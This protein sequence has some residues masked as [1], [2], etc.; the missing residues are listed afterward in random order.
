MSDDTEL[1]GIT[2]VTTESGAPKPG[3]VRG[4]LASTVGRVVVIVLA[5]VVLVGIALVVGF[6]VLG[7]SLFGTAPESV[8]T[9]PPPAKPAVVTTASPSAG[10]AT[11]STVASIAPPPVADIEDRD[12]FTPRDPFKPIPAPVIETETASASPGSGITDKSLILDDITSVNGVK[13]A[14][15][16]YNGT[17]YTLAEGDT[18]DS[19]PW[20]VLSIGTSSVV[21]LFGDDRITLTLGQGI[22]K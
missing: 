6:L 19:T 7:S 2:P 10:L 15:M 18:V 22:T 17:Q 9:A 16:T 4:F 1:T 8:V 13:K 14:I 3:G 21:M 12:V 20:K 11:S 5:V